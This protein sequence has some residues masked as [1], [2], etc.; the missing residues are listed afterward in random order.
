MA[1]LIFPFILTR[2]KTKRDD[3]DTRSI[4]LDIK[5]SG[6]TILSYA[7]AP[8][9]L[10]GELGEVTANAFI[11]KPKPVPFFGSPIHS[12]GNFFFP[13]LVSVGIFVVNHSFIFFLVLVRRTEQ[14]E[15]EYPKWVRCAF[16]IVKQ[17]AKVIKTLLTFYVNSSRNKIL[18]HVLK[19]G[20]R[21]ISIE[22]ERS[23]DH[24]V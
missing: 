1:F 15:F 24:W 21:D 19:T 22:W 13:E 5:Q 18:T 23:K 2:S 8:I 10:L 17:N 16:E 3:K 11:P 4:M 6:T 9:A 12:L 7:T 20:R 14:G